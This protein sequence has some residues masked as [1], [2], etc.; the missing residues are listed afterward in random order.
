MPVV[1]A[2]PFP[3]TLF[4][5][6]TVNG[7]AFPYVT[8]GSLQA[9]VDSVRTFSCSFRGREALEMCSIGAV[10]EV[11]IG[12]GNLTNLVDDRKFIGII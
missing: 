9:S 1:P 2:A 8:S 11:N 7:S 12:R 5:S 6:I 3:E 4:F 10:V